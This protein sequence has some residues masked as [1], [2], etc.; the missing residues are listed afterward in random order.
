MIFIDSNILI[1]IYGDDPRWA[2][3]SI[4]QLGLLARSE[5]LAINHIIVAEVA[6]R[7]GALGPFHAMLQT[8]SIAIEA[9]SDEAAFAAGEAFQRYKQRG[10]KIQTV[11][12]DF[13]IG[14]H[15]HTIGAT[16]LTRDSRFY[17]S[18]FP[19]VPLITPEKDDA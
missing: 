19:D 14:G 5:A 4:G 8:L 11:L 12:P 3:W 9:F 6:P 7:H 15:A 13:L 2:D 16:I 17:R 10:G 1:D 18:Y